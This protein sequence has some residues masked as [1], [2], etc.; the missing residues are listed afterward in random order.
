MTY[1][2]SAFEEKAASFS[3]ELSQEIMIIRELPVGA[4]NGMVNENSSS[5]WSGNGGMLTFP[6][7]SYRQ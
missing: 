5:L 1:A 6:E 3:G 7:L 4:G 2:V